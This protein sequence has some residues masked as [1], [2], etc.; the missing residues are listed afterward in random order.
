[1]QEVHQGAAA[2]EPRAW[3]GIPGRGG[4]TATKAG[5]AR[6]AELRRR[7]G[8]LT[9]RLG[10]NLRIAHITPNQASLRIH[11]A[12]QLKILS[13]YGVDSFGVSGDPEGFGAIRQGRETELFYELIEVPHMSR[14]LDPIA[15]ART[16]LEL[17]SILR[18]LRLDLVHTYGPKASYL[19]RIA[20]RWAGVPAVVHSPWGLY[21]GEQSHWSRKAV[22]LAVEAVSCHFGDAAISENKEDLERLRVL[23][24]LKLTRKPSRTVQILNS[25]DLSYLDPSQVTAE[26]VERCRERWGVAPGSIVVG[27]IGRVVREK[28][29]WEFIRAARTLR[30]RRPQCEFVIIGPKDYKLPND[31]ALDLTTRH[32]RLVGIQ[33]DIRVCFAALDIVVHPSHREGFPKTLVYA[34]AMGRPVVTTD[35]R[36]CREAIEPGVSGLLVPVGDADALARAIDTY[37]LDAGARAEAG[38]QGRRKALAQYDDLEHVRQTLEVYL[39]VLER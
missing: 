8:A 15:D 18:S 25:C 5:E 10:R 13:S 29:C 30:A 19:G 17:R 39:S 21:F 1:M 14:R 22:V 20:A 37:V 16:L 6:E 27:M 12:N 28:G 38:R 31:V 3:P 34:A 7:V 32:V 9:G 11:L 24:Q 33:D 4:P 36:G 26:E 2:A 23:E 35:T